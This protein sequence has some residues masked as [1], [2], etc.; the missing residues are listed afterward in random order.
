MSAGFFEGR[1]P[2]HFLRRLF[3]LDGK[4]FN[5]SVLLWYIGIS[6]EAGGGGGAENWLQKDKNRVAAYSDGGKHDAVRPA[7]G[8]REARGNGG[9]LTQL[10]GLNSEPPHVTHSPI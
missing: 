6:A 7:E 2:S 8:G 9:I 5:G 4:W 1:R 10:P 3:C